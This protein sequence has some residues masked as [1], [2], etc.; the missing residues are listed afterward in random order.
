MVDLGAYYY[1]W[2]DASQWRYSGF[3]HTP[4]LGL[5][6]SSDPK[7][8]AQHID[9]SKQNGIKF[10]AVSWA[11]K[12][13]LDHTLA[14]SDQN[15]RNQFL[16]TALSSG[17]EFAL[18][19]ES[20]ARLS[21]DANDSI[22]LDKPGYADRLVADLK[23]A[24]GY[25]DQPCYLK[26]NINGKPKPVVILYRARSFIGDVAATIHSVRKAIGDVYLVGD[27]VYWGGII[28]PRL[29]IGSPKLK[30][31]ERMKLYD[32]VTAYNMHIKDAQILADFEKKIERE[33][34]DWYKALSSVSV[35]FIPNVIPGYNDSKV[36]NRDNLPLPRSP[37]RFGRQLEIATKLASMRN[38]ALITSFNEWHEDTQIEP[39]ENYEPPTTPLSY[40][41]LLDS[42]RI[43]L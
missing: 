43:L 19:Y 38:I 37:V 13:G 21:P 29:R 3:I 12:E 39:A 33:Y 41:E 26:V 20:V 28:R 8:I 27:E 4:Q 30:D 35:D 22:D 1:L 24:A 40:L 17:F 36:P 18:L 23:D 42:R 31:P 9:W 14:R 25:F 2:Y 11:G 5:Y 34:G 7:T 15:L 6:N 16:P 32:G 10:F